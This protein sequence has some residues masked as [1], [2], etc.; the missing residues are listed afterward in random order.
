MK[1]ESQLAMGKLEPQ[2][3]KHPSE[4]RNDISTD[5]FDLKALATYSSCS[6]RWLRDR[7]VDRTYPLPHYRIEGKLLVKRDE[8]DQ[9]IAAHR[10]VRPT[11]QLTEIVESVVAQVCPPRRVA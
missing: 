9:W 6:V 5:Y 4:N 7:L 11:D 3:G 1:V 2:V 10:V 8:F